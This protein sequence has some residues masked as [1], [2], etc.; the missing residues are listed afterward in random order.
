MN[1]AIEL[2]LGMDRVVTS[3]E[4]LEKQFRWTQQSHK[5]KKIKECAIN[6]LQ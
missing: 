6:L 5:I 2:R 1:E 3:L 4:E